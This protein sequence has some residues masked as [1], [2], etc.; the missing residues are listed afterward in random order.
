MNNRRT[1]K[2]Y[3]DGGNATQGNRSSLTYASR[4]PRDNQIYYNVDPATNQIVFSPK[5]QAALDAWASRNPFDSR[6]YDRQGDGYRNALETLALMNQM[7]G[8]TAAAPAPGPTA[9]GATPAD[10]SGNPW[11]AELFGSQEGL[12]AFMSQFGEKSEAPFGIPEGSMA[13][14]TPSGTVAYNPYINQLY[15]MSPYAAEHYPEVYGPQGYNA[16]PP[17]P[18]P[19]PQEQGGGTPWQGPNRR[20]GHNPR[21]RQRLGQRFGNPLSSLGGNVEREQAR[22]SLGERF[23]FGPRQNVR[24]YAEGGGVSGF[25]GGGTRMNTPLAPL[26]HGGISPSPASWDRFGR[27]ALSALVGT[28]IPGAG[29]LNSALGSSGNFSNDPVKVAP[30]SDQS[31]LNQLT[32]GQAIRADTMGGQLGGSGRVGLNNRT[33]WLSKMADTPLKKPIVKKK[34]ADG[35]PITSRDT[36]EPL[37]DQQ[38]LYQR[39]LDMGGPE[40][41]ERAR[42]GE[43]VPVQLSSGEVIFVSPEEAHRYMERVSNITR[44]ADGGQVLRPDSTGYTGYGHSG[45]QITPPSVYRRQMREGSFNPQIRDAGNVDYG[46]SPFPWEEAGQSA[47]DFFGSQASPQTVPSGGMNAPG[48]GGNQGGLH[49]SDPNWKANAPVIQGGIQKT[50]F[51]PGTG[52]S[53]PPTGPAGSPGSATG[54]GGNNFGWQGISNP[55]MDFGAGGFQ[56]NKDNQTAF[57][58]PSNFRDGGGVQGYANGGTPKK[59]RSLNGVLAEAASEILGRNTEEEEEPK[60]WDNIEGP[61]MQ[62]ASTLAADAMSSYTQPP[63]ESLRSSASPLALGAGQG[64]QGTDPVIARASPALAFVNQMTPPA[65]A[66]SMPSPQLRPPQGMAQKLPQRMPQGAPQGAPQSPLQSIP[67]RPQGV[68]ANKPR[69]PLKQSQGRPQE[70]V[71]MSAVGTAD[72]VQGGAPQEREYIESV[73]ATGAT[74]DQLEELQRLYG[75]GEQFEALPRLQMA[76]TGMRRRFGSDNITP[77]E[78]SE[79]RS[80]AQTRQAAAGIMNNYIQQYA[81]AT[82]SGAEQERMMA[83][84]PNIGNNWNPLSGD[85]PA[86]FQAKVDGFR[87]YIMQVR[88]RASMRLALGATN[89]PLDFMSLDEAE[90]TFNQRAGQYTQELLRESPEMTEGAARQEAVSRLKEELGL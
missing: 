88:I 14:G 27:G 63:Q 23:G 81:G 82:V 86:T 74:L 31:V 25:T 77:E 12:D 57:G 83:F 7:G 50:P 60:W 38:S 75:E 59:S 3:Q 5:D 18:A 9:T 1:Y 46:I 35:G 20:Q 24:Q 67:Q 69:M 80:Y 68:P 58:G 53:M 30:A 56:W 85:D 34:A 87:R 22:T 48:L 8:N 11:I 41:F 40:G 64:G 29:A 52:P 70:D 13:H 73:N 65:A 72:S 33:N 89:T 2:G 71:P 90:R 43:R 28:A 39:A 79:L 42:S 66:G 10:I 54:G 21:Q 47:Q 44:Y 78:E 55:L 16:M 4:K 76:W 6:K 17:Q 36:S 51:M 32:S 37:W 49:G 45:Q 15:G 19:P 61:I 62:M 26:Q 84:L